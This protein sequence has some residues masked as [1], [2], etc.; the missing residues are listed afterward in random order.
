M[1]V[2]HCEEMGR[3]VLDAAGEIPLHYSPGVLPVEVPC[4]RY[5]SESN[6]LAAYSLGAAGV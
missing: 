6:M 1:I 5:V 2:F 3:K 4:L